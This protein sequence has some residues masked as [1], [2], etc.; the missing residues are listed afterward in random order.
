MADFPSFNISFLENKCVFRTPEKL[1]I[2][3]HD[4]RIH[5]PFVV[6]F[7]CVREGGVTYFQVIE[8]LYF[9][10]PSSFTARLTKMGSV[11]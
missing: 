1:E 5:I 2:N 3:T 10:I 7:I 8:F 9:T 6:Y 11:E 4:F